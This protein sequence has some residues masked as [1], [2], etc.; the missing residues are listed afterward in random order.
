MVIG[1]LIWK[2]RRDRFKFRKP[3]LRPAFSPCAL[4]PTFA[5]VLINLGLTNPP[6]RMLDPFCGVGSILIEAALMGIYSIGIDVKRTLIKECR[7][8]LKAYSS[9]PLVDLIVADAKS[10]PLREEAIRMVMTD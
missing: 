8:N 5:K 1:D 2:F 10:L 7:R 9:Y 6:D 3:D 4:T